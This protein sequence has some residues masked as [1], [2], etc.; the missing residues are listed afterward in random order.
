MAESDKEILQR[1]WDALNAV[2]KTL[3][4]TQQIA[5]VSD[6]RQAVKY[7]SADLPAG[8]D[9]PGFCLPKGIAPLLPVFRE[10]ILNGM[11]EEKENAAQGLGEV[12]GLTCA[13]SLQPSVVH[14]T[15][16]LIRILGDRFNAN[17]KAAVLETL[18]VLLYKVGIMLKQFLPQLQTTF[19]KALTDANRAVRMK[20]GVA[21]SELIKIH[22]RP[23]PLFVEMHNGIKNADD[24]A[25]RETML[26]ALRGVTTK[27]GDKITELLRKQMYA[28]LTSMLNYSEDVTRSCVAGCFG[29]LLRWLSEELLD[30]ALNNHIFND[31]FGEDWSLRHGRTAA[32][33]VVL[34]ESPTTVY[35][36]KYE[37]KL[38]KTLITCMQSDKLTVA[39]N[40][41]RGTCYLIQH[42]LNEGLP[43]PV[44]VLT[45]FVKSMNHISNEVKQ[46]LAKTIIHLAKVVPAEKTSPELLKALIPMLVNGTKEKNGYVKSNSEIALVSILRL[47]NGDDVHKKV[48][49]LLEPG[50]QESLN[51]TVAK[52]TNRALAP[53]GKDEEIDDTLLS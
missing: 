51:E 8:A 49:Q 15:G 22:T 53:A 43:I 31:D 44:M 36:P 34:K 27:N 17:V 7:A 6:V 20:A 42:C 10:A 35:I 26:Q 33:F 45:P 50:A 23:D 13:A 25:I 30:E 39:S 11:P 5:H 14:I 52:V 21:I 9:L 12:I 24:S 41:V 16:P 18:A 2:T 3:D 47:K 4:S 19:L 1:S 40:G 46:L 37:V 28:T 38:C 48:L 32:L 29:A